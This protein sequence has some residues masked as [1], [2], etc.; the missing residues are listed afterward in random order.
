MELWVQAKD[1]PNY[2]VS[3]EG[4]I[5]NVKTKRTLKTHI[6]RNG[7]EELVLRKDNKPRNQKVHRLVADSF[8]DGDHNGL[9]V[10]HIDGNKANNHISNLEWCTRKENI[11][12]A[13][14]HGLATSS[15]SMKVKIVETGETYNSFRECAKDIGVDPSNIHQYFSGKI[16]TCK[17]YTFE[18]C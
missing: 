13:F 16:K 17:G 9:D 11:A 1:F 5:R 15:R 6:N 12:H 14:K 8:Y 2:E 4:R 10:N 7:Y 3:S 18:K